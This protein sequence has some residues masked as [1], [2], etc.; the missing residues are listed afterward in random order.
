MN[1]AFLF[2]HSSH[3]HRAPPRPPISTVYPSPYLSDSYPYNSEYGAQSHVAHI[4]MDRV[5]F[6]A[7]TPFHSGS[8]EPIPIPQAHRRQARLTYGIDHSVVTSTCAIIMLAVIAALYASGHETFVGSIDGPP[9]EAAPGLVRNMVMA[10][11]VYAV[12][13]LS[14]SSKSRAHASIGSPW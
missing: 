13:S 11:I 14:L 1:S 2:D 9:P 12:R 4:G 7:N 10:M 8:A 5:M 3:Y 6:P